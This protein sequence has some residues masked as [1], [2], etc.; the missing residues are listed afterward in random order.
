ML[1]SSLSYPHSLT[2]SQPEEVPR[3]TIND[4]VLVRLPLFIWNRSLGQL[5]GK[6]TSDYV[7]SELVDEDEQVDETEAS[8]RAAVPANANGEA[9]KR[10]SK[11]K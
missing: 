5:L 8:L 6:Q 4:T 11:V 7:V 10:R 3:P 2:S 9:R 1:C